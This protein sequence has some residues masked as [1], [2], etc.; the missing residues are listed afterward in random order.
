MRTT[1]LSIKANLE[2]CTDVEPVDNEDYPHDYGFTI[3][4]K[5]CKFRHP[6]QIMVNRFDTEHV[7][8]YVNKPTRV[9]NFSIKCKDCRRVLFIILKRT[10]QSLTLQDSEHDTFVP[11]LDVHTH[12]CII[13]D[14]SLEDQF[15]CKTMKGKVI[16]GVDLRGNDWSEFD[17]NGN[18]PMTITDFSYKLTTLDGNAEVTKLND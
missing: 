3:E 14:F 7:Q 11:I 5:A 13:I 9:V 1:V 12:G 6:K 2:N 18:V 15:Q 10:E 16:D 17:E 8:L 4:C